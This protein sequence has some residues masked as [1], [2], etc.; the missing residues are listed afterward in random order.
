[1][2]RSMIRRFTAILL[3]NSTLIFLGSSNSWIY[4]QAS[5]EDEKS[6][7]SVTNE[8]ELLQI[9]S[10]PS[11]DSADKAM[12][13]KRLA[14]Y[15]SPAVSE[16]L[17]KL[18]TD[19]EL[20][21]W[22]RIALEAIPGEQASAVLRQTLGQVEGLLQI[23]IINS[24]AARRDE[25]SIIPLAQIMRTGS[26]ETVAAAAFALGKIGTI[27]SSRELTS[28]F[29][30]SSPVI[31]A[32]V[33]EGCIYCAD[34]LRKADQL[35]EA[36]EIYDMIRLSELPRQR[37][38]EATR[39]SILARA[40][41]GIPLL[42]DLLGSSDY[43][44]FAL[45]LQTAREM[46]SDQVGRSL[47]AEI[48]KS[49]PERAALLVETLGDLPGQAD[50]V[51]L[52]S[53]AQKGSPEVRLAAINV[54]GRV[55]D[56]SILP[57]MLVLARES[58]DLQRAVRVA[59]VEVADEQVDQKILNLLADAP[60]EDK[61][62]LIELVGLRQLEATDQLVKMLENRSDIIRS[63]ALEALGQTIPQSRLDV[64]ISRVVAPRSPQDE[65]VALRALRVAAVRMPNREECAEQLGSAMQT[66][67][68]AVKSQLLPI[69]A[70]VGGAKALK[71]VGENG[72]SS[73]ESMRD[74]STKLL[75]EWMTIDVAPVLLDLATKG[76][77]DRF[78]IRA[79]RGYIRVA[80]QFVMPEDQ[81]I[82][83]C[84]TA[85]EAAK[86]VAEQRLVLD[87]LRRYP[88]SKGLEIAI[89]SL[90]KSNLR[91]DARQAISV[92]AEKLSDNP[93]VQQR[94]QELG[95]F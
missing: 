48:A 29:S 72:F 94:L 51:S 30:E 31:R 60:E 10:S 61:K 25:N 5:A 62:I 76:P 71:I 49:T 67:T 63:A 15:G 56:A 12:A 47:I 92:I 24:L 91:E 32:A 64:L 84:Q 93:Q 19:P 36:I 6:V 18:L 28:F 13:C 16:E 2:Y 85:M 23:G 20:S 82:E 95:E 77:M 83:M 75:G 65:S 52:Q 66:A 74:L 40:D 86:N 21:S 80:R 43:R 55:G 45:G 8:E 78:Q 14:V 35:S 58:G 79:L 42:I 54:L 88:T 59:L 57:T 87:V 89:D 39:G 70:A 11:A 27:Q 69:V 34:Q 1:M 44:L 26:P 73:D 41:E 22:A 38:V 7:S 4:G 46:T 37:V 9:L 81:R 33:A 3:L 50:L 68:V 53:L 90:N 17:G